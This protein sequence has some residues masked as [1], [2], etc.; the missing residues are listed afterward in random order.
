MLAHLKKNSAMGQQHWHQL[1]A[2]H[3][4]S[5]WNVRSLKKVMSIVGISTKKCNNLNFALL[6]RLLL[7]INFTFGHWTGCQ[8]DQVTIFECRCE[9]EGFLDP[10]N[11]N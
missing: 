2:V 6:Q 8:A 1:Y 11:G 7:V 5:S 3:I 9:R 10:G 4:K